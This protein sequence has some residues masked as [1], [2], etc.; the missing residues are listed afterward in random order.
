[1]LIG[2]TGAPTAVVNE[3]LAGFLEGSPGEQVSFVRGGPT[4]LVAG[5]YVPVEKLDHRA[6]WRGWGGSV[7][8]GG[9]RA[10]TSADLDAVIESLARHHIDALS[11]VGGNGTM[12]FLQAIAERAE[13]RGSSLRVVGIPKTIDND[14]P[15]VDH[16]PG[17]A[18]AASYLSQIM[19]D[20]A[21]D[22][23]A[24]SSIEPVRLVETMGR[25]TGWLAAAAA[26]PGE[27]GESSVDLV[28]TPEQALSTECFLSTLEARVADK[29]RVLAVVSEGVFPDLSE[30]PVGQKNHAT[31]VTGGVSRLLA[32]QIGQQL[33]LP[34]RAEVLGVVQRSAA[35]LSSATDRQEAYDVGYR[36]A[37]VLVGSEETGVMVGI[38][39]V[40]GHEYAPQYSLVPLVDLTD[41]RPLPAK[42]AHEDPRN[43]T[44]FFEWL[45]PLLRSSASQV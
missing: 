43:M 20:L 19:P 3:S 10:V 44:D 7:I 9:R 41:V 35:A 25:A 32:D 27:S 28:I 11:L 14:L 23:Q 26:F 42:W 38:C 12:A 5:D 29:G 21:R 40:D 8:G 30:Q 34:V 39:R 22:H 17:F 13:Q 4:G 6:G 37:Q 36:A 45:N 1:M 15:G 31:L 18:S 2:Q 24:M 16:S 33:G